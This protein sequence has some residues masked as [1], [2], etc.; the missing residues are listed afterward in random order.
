MRNNVLPEEYDPGPDGIEANAR[1]L[2]ET[3]N[4][5]LPPEIVPDRVTYTLL[6]QCYAYQG[7]LTRTLQIF[8]DMLSS[9]DPVAIWRGEGETEAKFV[10][11]LPIFRAIF[12][13]FYRHTVDPRCQGTVPEPK[14]PVRKRTQW[15][16]D[17]LNTIY[18]SFLRLPVDQKPGDRVVYWLIMAYAK[19][20]GY[21][22]R[23]L[24]SVW[25]RLERRFGNDWGPRLQRIRKSIYGNTEHTSVEEEMDEM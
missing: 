12:L 13:G 6:I 11:L 21:S 18:K 24:R 25:K 2:D 14:L 20:S 4:I 19:S 10:P 15:C 8:M 3:E 1:F 22:T 7:D 5:V 23:K 16:M 9:P 17:N